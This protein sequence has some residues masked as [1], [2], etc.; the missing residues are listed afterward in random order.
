[1]MDYK[2]KKVWFF[3]VIPLVYSS[4]Q[5]DWAVD[6]TNS[7]LNKLADFIV[8]KTLNVL[9]YFDLQVLLSPRNSKPLVK[10]QPIT[11]KLPNRLLT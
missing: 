9:A 4:N 3:R 10:K 5:T 7:T 8:T 1:M 11:E 2:G 6:V